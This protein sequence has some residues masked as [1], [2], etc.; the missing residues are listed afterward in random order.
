MGPREQAARIAPTI[1]A[2]NGEKVTQAQLYK[3]LYDLDQGLSERFT[4]VLEAIN[5]L[6]S[7]YRQHTADGHP[8]TQRAE[9]IKEEIKLDAKKAAIVAALLTVM[10]IIIASVGDVIARLF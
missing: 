2:P 4:V 6:R 1:D 8:F 5:G 7:D 10:G 3:G 9:V